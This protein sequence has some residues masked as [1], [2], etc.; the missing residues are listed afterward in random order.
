[1]PVNSSQ[2]RGVVGAFDSRFI[3]IKQ[4]NIFK[5][6]FSQS[7]VKQT[8]AKEK[9]YIIYKFFNI[10]IISSSWSFVNLFQI[11]ARFINLSVFSI[12]YI[13]ILLAFIHHILLYLITFNRIGDIEQI[14]GPNSN[15]YQS[16]F[17]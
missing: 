16:F 4:H 14:P 8:I 11:K 2:Y 10:L 3:H 6:A 9:F 15:S 13:C 17:I 12:S 7:K 1:M 5:N